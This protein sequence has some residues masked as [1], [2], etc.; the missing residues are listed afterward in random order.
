MP[1]HKMGLL[2]NEAVVD[3]QFSEAVSSDTTR[4]PRPLFLTSSGVHGVVNID[5]T[6]LF[7]VADGAGLLKI[8]LYGKF[9]D[10][11]LDCGS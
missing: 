2:G 7:P 10:C 4:D 9:S 3:V 6:N 11:N 8:S 5:Y 1:A